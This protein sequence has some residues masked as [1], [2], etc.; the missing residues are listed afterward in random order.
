[1]SHYVTL[2]YIMLH[3]VTLCH[4]MLHC[5]TEVSTGMV[6]SGKLLC[7]GLFSVDDVAHWLC[8]VTLS[9]CLNGKS[10]RF[11][12]HIIYNSTSASWERR[13]L[14]RVPRSHL[15][16]LDCFF[17]YFYWYNIIFSLII[18]W[19][20]RRSVSVRS[21]PLIFFLSSFQK[22]LGCFYF[23]CKIMFYN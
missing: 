7:A 23:Y 20:N 17:M 16:N 11:L 2:Y 13:G 6:S 5:I 15:T 22:S 21:W 9:H 4:I 10:L 14:K 1:M 8:S 18:L 19:T 3:Y 12:S